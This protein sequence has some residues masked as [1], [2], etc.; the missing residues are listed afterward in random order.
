MK[1]AVVD[2]GSNT[3]RLSVY[4]P[5]PE[6]KFELLFSE[7]V[8]AGLANDIVD[9]T[10]S[11]E[12][13][14]RACAV[15]LD[16]RSLLHQFG[17]E[18]MHVFATA[19]LRNIRNTEEALDVIGRKT[20]LEVDV[21][22]GDL[23]AELGYYGV[24][25][26]TELENGAMF[27]IGGGSTEIV[28]VREGRILRAQSLPVGSLNLFTRYVSKIWPKRSEAEEIYAA[29]QE[30]LEG[31]RL[32]SAKAGLVCGVGGTARAVLKI[33][34]SYYGRTADN[35][36]LMGKELEKLTAF[37]MKRDRRARKL[38]LSACPDRI[39]T[40]LPGILLMQGLCGELC[41]KEL[42][43]S[44]YGVREGYLCHRLLDTGI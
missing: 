10:L 11:Q 28:E 2:L 7:K 36:R 16:F 19:S 27:D 25:C 31:A 5:L 15:L 39:H 32:P 22:P 4:H 21:V 1:I 17:M 37:L 42:Y 24:L 8:M 41:G 38:I 12:G 29:V 20:G 26:T 9:G 18:E 6:G 34:N 35:R 14:D 44:Q 30:M 23:E 13:I 3:I 43:I 33:A 40:I